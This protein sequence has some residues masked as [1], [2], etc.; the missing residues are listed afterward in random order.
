MSHLNTHSQAIPSNSPHAPKATG[1]YLATFGTIWNE[2]NELLLLHRTDMDRWCLP[3]GLLDLGESVTECLVRECREELGVEIIQEEL[4]G[5]YSCPSR[6]LFSFSDGRVI[7][8]IVM[9][10]NVSVLRG[11]PT[12][13]GIESR[14][15]R[16]FSRD[17][18]PDI[19]PS[20]RIWVQDAFE[21]AGTP[22]IR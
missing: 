5:I 3:G 10:F 12:S 20:H 9:V 11:I 19:V 13:D 1:V 4:L 21:R 8:Y 15:L 17:A 6:H 2:K 22:F 7:H 18:L 14:D 16:Y